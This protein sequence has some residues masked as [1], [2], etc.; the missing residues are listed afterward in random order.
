ML[1]YGVI[2]DGKEETIHTGNATFTRCCHNDVTCFVFHMRVKSENDPL[3][4]SAVSKLNFC[5][6]E[7]EPNVPKS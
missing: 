2:L 4:C 6:T 1:S 5:F 3:L 7:P